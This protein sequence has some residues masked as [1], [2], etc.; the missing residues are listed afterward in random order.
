MSDYHILDIS[1]DG[2][3]VSV[4]FHVPIDNV[5]N[6]VG[7]N[8]RTALKQYLESQSESGTITSSLPGIDS[9]ELTSLQNGEKYEEKKDLH[10]NV[11]LSNV[12]KLAIVIQTFTHDSIVIKNAISSRLKFWGKSGDVV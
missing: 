12:E 5:N 3:R 10:F 9:V 11:F 1:G 6:S 2:Q 7:V 8:L 4:I